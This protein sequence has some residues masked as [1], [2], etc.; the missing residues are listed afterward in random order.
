MGEV[1]AFQHPGQWGRRRQECGSG[2]SP[3]VHG[4]FLQDQWWRRVLSAA[5]GESLAGLMASK[6]ARLWGTPTGV[7][8]TG[9][10]YCWEDHSPWKGCHIAAGEDCDLFSA[11][12]GRISG[13]N[14]DWNGMDCTSIPYHPAP[15]WGEEV[16]DLDLGRRERSGAGE[17]CI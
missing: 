4:E 8:I 15:L 11:W 5:S 13:N 12:G 10:I 3:S 7:G 9:V 16:A 6:R 2:H 17:K 1:Q 14:M